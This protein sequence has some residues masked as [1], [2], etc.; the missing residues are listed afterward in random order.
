MPCGK[1]TAHS[2]AAVTN[3]LPQAQANA[4]PGLGNAPLE[5]AAGPNNG[6]QPVKNKR[7]SGFI[8]PVKRRVRTIIQT[9][10]NPAVHSQSGSL[11]QAA[12]AVKSSAP[13]PSLTNSQAASKQRA[14]T[15]DSGK[16]FASSS[17]PV[18]GT[19]PPAIAAVSG[20]VNTRLELMKPAVSHAADIATYASGAF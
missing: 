7:K 3:G 5:Q 16:S 17:E 2:M 4:T 18:Q 19:A 8:M 1:S 15:M 10:C 12:T 14:P 11:Q 13:P 6:G 9:H 20:N